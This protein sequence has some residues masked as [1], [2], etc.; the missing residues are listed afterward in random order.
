MQPTG[1]LERAAASACRSRLLQGAVSQRTLR[2]RRGVYRRWSSAGASSQP[3]SPKR[4]PM[5]S[6]FTRVVRPSRPAPSYLRAPAVLPARLHLQPSWATGDPS[7]TWTR[8][9]HPAS[10][11]TSRRRYRPRPRRDRRRDRT[12][13][14]IRRLESI[15][16]FGPMPRPL[17]DLG[18]EAF[19]SAWV[20]L[21]A[22]ETRKPQV[23]YRRPDPAWAPLCTP[24]GGR[25]PG[26]EERALRHR[27][28]SSAR[29]P[30]AAL[31]L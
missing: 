31:S 14:G 29:P 22:D 9:E 10:R 28:I 17:R 13:T 7:P 8:D 5:G 20:V 19:P 27:P 21:E 6:C 23:P 26:H 4:L 3:S 25:T 30:R 1:Y 15:T 24:R 2:V 12:Q 11:R 16:P 18:A